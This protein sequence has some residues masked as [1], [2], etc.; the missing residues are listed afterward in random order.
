MSAYRELL[1]MVAAHARMRRNLGFGAFPVRTGKNVVSGVA[2]KERELK[3]LE[4][5]VVLCTLC[6]L[7][8]TRKNVVFGEGRCDAELMFVGEGPGY[9]EDVQGRPFVG[10]A[11]RLLTKMINAMGFDRKD[12]Y[13]ANVVKCRP[14]GNRN[15]ESDEIDACFPYLL[16]QIKI[17]NP[18]VIVALGKFA[19]QTLI[20]TSTPISRLRGE[21]H[22]SVAGVKVMPTFHPAYLLRNPGSKKDAWSDLKKVMSYL[23]GK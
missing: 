15:P 21:F 13:I 16:E 6:K 12:V 20:G 18:K 22:V 2:A 8:A 14:P 23:K 4:K 5:D 9:E 10:A 11:G 19:A 17:I 1:E 7:H 3:K